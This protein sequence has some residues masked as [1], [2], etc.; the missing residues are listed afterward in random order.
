MDVRLREEPLV[1]RVPQPLE[2]VHLERPQRVD[3]PELV[4][5]EHPAARARHARELRDRE[6]RT[7]DVMQEPDMAAM[8]NSA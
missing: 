6:L 2:T 4:D 7:P 3:R 1:R 5:D 8:S